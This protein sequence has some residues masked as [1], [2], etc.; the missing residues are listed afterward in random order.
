[1]PCPSLDG[2]GVVYSVLLFF[3][4][5]VVVDRPRAGRRASSPSS[6]RQVCRFQIVTLPSSAFSL[7]W[8]LRTSHTKRPLKGGR[9][10]WSWRS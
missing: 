7:I 1:M 3:V 8:K 10:F 5:V 6:Y 2:D 4:V 9:G